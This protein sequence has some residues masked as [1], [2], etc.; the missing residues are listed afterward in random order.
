MPATQQADPGS[1]SLRK[2]CSY[3]CRFPISQAT[4]ST[5]FAPAIYIGTLRRT[6][7]SQQG[8]RRRHQRILGIRL[9]HDAKTR[10]QIIKRNCSRF[11]SVATTM[12]PELTPSRTLAP[13]RIDLW[14]A[15][16]RHTAEHGLRHHESGAFRCHCRC[17]AHLR[18]LDSLMKT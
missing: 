4:R 1:S 6:A 9:W 15:R 16:L 10:S 2:M 3:S 17:A 7:R 12:P 14:P 11:A 8:A 13:F 18:S 5:S